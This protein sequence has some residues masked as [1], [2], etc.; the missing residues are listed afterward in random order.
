MD[1]VLQTIFVFVSNTI[2][3][4]FV[5]HIVQITVVIEENVFQNWVVSVNLDF[6]D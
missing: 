2:M 3:E 4:H 5:K 6:Q 1:C